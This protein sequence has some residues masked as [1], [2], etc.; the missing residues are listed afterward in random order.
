[1]NGGKSSKSSDR[2]LIKINIPIVMLDNEESRYV[3]I[4][5]GYYF[6]EQK[7]IDGDSWYVIEGTQTGRKASLFPYSVSGV[8]V[9]EFNNFMED[10]KDAL[11]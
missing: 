8:Y 5:S 3:W 1:M 4:K 10:L 7:W 6:L 11:E 2:I 9:I